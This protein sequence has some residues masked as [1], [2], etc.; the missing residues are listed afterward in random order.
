MAQ[1]GRDYFSL[2]V[3]VLVADVFVASGCDVFSVE[4][5]ILWGERFM[6]NFYGSEI[7]L[8]VL[9]NEGRKVAESHNKGQKES[10]ECLP[11]PSI[12]ET[13]M[14]ELLETAKETS[15]LLEVAL[16]DVEGK[17]RP[18][19]VLLEELQANVDKLRGFIFC[20]RKV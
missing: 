5:Y 4:V 6:E 16:N 14:Q 1:D 18:D 2:S 15:M 11:M 8:A 20:L 17:K 3:F 7:T 10:R 19:Q 9:I 13:L 12:V